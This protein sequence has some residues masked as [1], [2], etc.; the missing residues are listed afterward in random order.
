M[1]NIK[2]ALKRLIIKENGAVSIYVIIVTLLLFIFNAVL[3]D[4]ARIMVAEHQVEQAAKAAIR[5]SFSAFN[6][7]VQ[8]KGLFVI[9]DQGKESPQEIFEKVFKENLN[10]ED[11]KYFKFVNT[12]MESANFTSNVERSFA[13]VEIVK[14]QILEE[15]K[16]KAPI[17]FS[18]VIIDGLLPYSCALKEADVLINAS[19]DVDKLIKDRDKSMKKAIDNISKAQDKLEQAN[20]IINGNKPSTYPQLYNLEN[21]VS[22]YDEYDSDDEDSNDRETFEK[23]LRELLVNIRKHADSAYSEIKKAEKSVNKAEKYNAKIYEKITETREE[24]DS[25]YKDLDESQCSE[26]VAG[27]AQKKI[28]DLT[29]ELNDYVMESKEFDIMKKALKDAKESIKE[30][31]NDLESTKLTPQAYYFENRVEEDLSAGID[32]VKTIR[33][34]INRRYVVAFNKLEEARKALDENY[35]ARKKSDKKVE[36]SSLKDALAKL[37]EIKKIIAK[38]KSGA[39]DFQKYADLKKL[40]S[41]YGSALPENA[42]DLDM[43]DPKL[44]SKDSFNIISQLINTVSKS[45]TDF[46]DDMYIN[47]YILTRFKSDDKKNIFSLSSYPDT[48]LFKNR[49]VEYILFG[50]HKSGVNY[51]QAIIEISGIRFGLN[52]ISAFFQAEVKLLVHPIPKM[53]AALSWAFTETITDL[54]KL[55]SGKK[56][57]LVKFKAGGLLQTDYKFY[58]RLLFMIHPDKDNQR[59]HRIQ[60]VVDDKASANLINAPTYATGKVEAS[61]DLW[62]LPGIINMLGS[63]GVLEGNVKNG[64]YH[65]TKEIDYSY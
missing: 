15:M 34:M 13:N 59:I 31:D 12:K 14:H 5:S 7:D 20:S 25:K 61:V 9:N 57:D 48:L 33:V 18:L 50:H 55:T 49:E 8:D 40:V 65:M 28:K 51:A 56:V 54:K 19:D 2:A 23:N 47:E 30:S 38:I 39:D 60:A 53:L 10:I 29:D 32:S 21:A 6:K 64:K 26:E 36:E 43:E 63:T 44:A 27:E 22:L 1:K 16:Y 58:L 41:A 35:Q 46:R 62:F 42:G 3:I 4:F 45:A 11:E 37:K 24:M 52:F 17:E